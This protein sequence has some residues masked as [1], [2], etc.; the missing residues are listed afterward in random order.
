MEGLKQVKIKNGKITIEGK[1]V[2]AIPLKMAVIELNDLDYLGLAGN[3]L[4]R[5]LI[6][7]GYSIEEIEDEI[8]EDRE[9]LIEKKPKEANAYLVEE[10]DPFVEDFSGFGGL[11]GGENYFYPVLYLKIK[12]GNEK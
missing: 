8:N 4:K 2:D 12:E 10:E 9:N 3:S 1:V 6:K 5:Q 7:D 11:A